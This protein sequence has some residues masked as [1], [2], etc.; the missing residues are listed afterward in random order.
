MRA[1]RSIAGDDVV[2]LWAVGKDSGGVQSVAIIGSGS[3]QCEGTGGLVFSET[4]DLYTSHDED[5]S[6]GDGDRTESSRN[7]TR[8]FRVSNFR[9]ACSSG[10]TLESGV[11][12]FEA[13]A[14]NFGF[15]SATSQRVKITYE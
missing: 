2:H 5:P 7:H 11:I 3:V 14:M 6:V 8:E 13:I 9:D 10:R 4:I 15:G 12:R 1:S